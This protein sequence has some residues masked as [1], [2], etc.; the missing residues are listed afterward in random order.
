MQVRA[1]GGNACLCLRLAD[2]EP[3]AQALCPSPVSM[4]VSEHVSLLCPHGGGARPGAPAT[5]NPHAVPRKQA[6]HPPHLHPP[7]YP[8]VVIT[9]QFFYS[10]IHAPLPFSLHLGISS[11]FGFLEAPLCVCPQVVLWISFKKWLFFMTCHGICSDNHSS[12]M[13]QK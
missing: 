12:T 10:Q 1:A 2:V 13:W 7:P 9:V 6:V 11:L 4:C 5:P 8:P 3:N